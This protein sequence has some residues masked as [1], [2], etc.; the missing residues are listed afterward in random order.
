MKQSTV[1]YINTFALLGWCL[2]CGLSAVLA[3]KGHLTGPTVL[4]IALG[5]FVAIML[6]NVVVRF[7]VDPKQ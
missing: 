3:V 6:F 1:K 5:L 2:W 7:F 4:W